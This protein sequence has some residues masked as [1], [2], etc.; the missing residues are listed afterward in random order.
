MHEFS[1]VLFHVNLMDVNHLGTGGSID[2]HPAIITDRQIE[3]GDL[4][5]LRIIRIE[6]VFTV[7]AAVRM[8]L[9]VGSQ[10]YRYRQF[11]HTLIENRQ[12]A[13]H[14]GAYRTG[15]GIRRTAKGRG[16]SAKDLRLR[17]QF[18]MDFQSDHGFILYTHQRASFLP[19]S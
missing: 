15:V 13:G 4:V 18:H 17:R 1:R 10:S 11:Y 16:T 2:F 9:A 8:Y 19:H 7:K 3:L 6:I 5:I 12:R 14:S